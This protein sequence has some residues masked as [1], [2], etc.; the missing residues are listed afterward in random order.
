MAELTVIPASP[1]R[2]ARV[3]LTSAQV[4]A[5]FTTPVQIIAAPG[6]GKIIFPTSASV[7]Y[8]AGATPYTDHGGSLLLQNGANWFSFA[9]LG[10]W[11]QAASQIYMNGSLAFQQ[12]AV[13]TFANKQLQITQSTANPTLGDGTLVVTVEYRIVSVS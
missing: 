1:V 11:D 7:N 8:V 10:F 6:A 9:T 2:V 3:T 5:I 13:S 4:L 12:P